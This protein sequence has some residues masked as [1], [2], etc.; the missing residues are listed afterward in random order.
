MLR[1]SKWTTFLWTLQIMLLCNFTLNCCCCFCFEAMTVIFIPI[2]TMYFSLSLYF[3]CKGINFCTPHCTISVTSKFLCHHPAL[4]LRWAF[5][6][7]LQ[8]LPQFWRKLLVTNLAHG[9]QVKL[10]EARP[11]K[12]K[13]K[14]MSVSLLCCWGW[15]L[16]SGP[17]QSESYSLLIHL[18]I[19]NVAGKM[20]NTPRLVQGTKHCRNRERETHSTCDLSDCLT[21]LAPDCPPPKLIEQLSLFGSPQQRVVQ[22]HFTEPSILLRSALHDHSIVSRL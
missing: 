15:H 2:L 18:L 19:A 7:L 16:A 13:K 3:M 11:G 4:F 12:R 8:P 22:S 17:A 1:N 10:I 20:F 21:V 9:F 5:V 14:E 6:C